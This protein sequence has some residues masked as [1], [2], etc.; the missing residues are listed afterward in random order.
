MTSCL[1]VP[2]TLDDFRAVIEGCAIAAGGS[3]WFSLATLGLQS[4]LVA[5][6]LL[7]TAVAVLRRVT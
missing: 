7:F 1:H 4:V 2:S 6:V 5:G 3:D